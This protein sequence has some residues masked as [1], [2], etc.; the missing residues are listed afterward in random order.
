MMSVNLLLECVKK[1]ESFV[2]C[3]AV[4]SS[5]LLLLPSLVVASK[6]TVTISLCGESIFVYPLPSDP[7]DF[8]CA[9]ANTAA[10]HN[11]YDETVRWNTWITILLSMT[12]ITIS[13][14]LI[15]TLLIPY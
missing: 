2:F 6:P 13:V 11:V 9:F 3:V 7:A 15:L 14:I 1:N 10:E 5:W 8:S 4:L 12:M